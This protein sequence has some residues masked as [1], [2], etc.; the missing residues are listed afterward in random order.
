MTIRSNRLA[1]C[2]LG[3]VG[4]SFL[5]ILRSQ[6][7]LLRERYR[8]A[9]TV[10]GVAD[11]G[12][13]ALD[14]T[15]LDIEA[16]LLAKRAK[17]SV[18]TLPNVGRT[19]MNALAMAQTVDADILLEATPVDLQQGKPGIDITRAALR[20]G[21]S[22]VLANKG[23]LA[24][25]YTELAEKSDLAD[26]SWGMRRRAVG[27]EAPAVPKP[28]LRFSACVGG[29]MPT[30]NIGRRDLAGCRIDRVEAVLNGTTHSMLRAME[31]GMSYIEALIDAQKRGI[32]ETDPMLDIHGW[33]AAVKLTILANAVLDCPV[34]L[35]D[36]SVEG[37]ALLSTE[38]LQEAMDR[39]E[40]IVLL[41][42]AKR[43]SPDDQDTKHPYKLSV[44]PTALPQNHPLAR[45]DGHEM[46]VVYYTDIAGRASATTRER[47]AVPTA[48]AM[49]RDVLDIV[50]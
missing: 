7:A 31:T 42:L 36:V 49:L 3:N 45:M 2:G 1:L 40:R 29:A 19:D 38:E 13:A 10:V 17:Q 16:I 23:P 46:G 14:P 8:V 30:I 33:D 35:S 20:R 24:L 41:A 11:S 25:A 37:I 44:R 43:T 12:G 47:D 48:A 5:G 18:A 50:Q 4:R 32:A 28:A 15:G 9:F 6:E 22:V 26:Q 39:G 21:I 34:S 27:E